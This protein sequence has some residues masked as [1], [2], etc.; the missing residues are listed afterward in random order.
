[1]YFSYIQIKIPL[2]ITVTEYS[3]EIVYSCYLN[4]LN[5][6]RNFICLRCLCKQNHNINRLLKWEFTRIHKDNNQT[7]NICSSTHSKFKRIAG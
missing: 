3:I 1:M 5:I 2:I 7:N 6:E 4:E